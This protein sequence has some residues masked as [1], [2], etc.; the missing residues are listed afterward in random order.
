M[1][2]SWNEIRNRA[3]E[4]SKRWEGESSERAEAQSLWNEFSRSESQL[5]HATCKKTLKGS[6]FQH[7]SLVR[8]ASP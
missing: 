2:P 8:N 4:F 5:P 3:H 6:W 7:K 1:P